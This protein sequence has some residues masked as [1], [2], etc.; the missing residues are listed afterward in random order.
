MTALLSGGALLGQEE[1]Q[2]QQADGTYELKGT[3]APIGSV[4]DSFLGQ[5][6]AAHGGDDHDPEFYRDFCREFSIDSDWPSA[7]RLGTVHRQVSEEYAER[8]AQARDHPDYKDDS[9]QDPNDWRVQAVG[10]AFAEVYEDLRQDGLPYEFHRFVAVIELQTRGTF[11]QY[12]TEPMD[13]ERLERQEDLFWSAAGEV[14]S[15]A[16]RFFR[17]EVER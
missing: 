8:L 2:R 1:A 13:R 4:L 15:E 5:A 7:E 10:R 9:G 17:Q 6:S 11:V 14:S 3:V 12:S 16:A